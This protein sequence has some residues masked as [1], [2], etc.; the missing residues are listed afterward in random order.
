MKKKNR[1]TKRSALNT[2][3]GMSVGELKVLANAVL[4]PNC[5]Q[6]LRFLLRKSKMAV[7]SEKES[8]ELDQILEECDHLALLKAKAQ[9][10]LN[11]S[12][13]NA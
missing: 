9:Y 11:E 6:R 7:L 4:V 12:T 2:L 10:T 8:G 5:Q 13:S 1:T 3:S